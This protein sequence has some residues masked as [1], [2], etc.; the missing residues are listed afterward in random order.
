MTI[1]NKR[2]L[3]AMTLMALLAVIHA[4]DEVQ[5]QAW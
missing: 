5:R 1:K 4:A 2:T 3:I